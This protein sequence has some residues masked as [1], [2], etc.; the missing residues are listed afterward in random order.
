MGPSRL[1]RWGLAFALS[2]SVVSPAS[3]QQRFDA[4]RVD[5]ARL[6]WCLS[7][8]AEC[9]KPAADR[10][11]SEKSL[12]PATR[13]EKAP[14]VGSTLVLADRRR[15]DGERC[16]GFAFIECGPRLRIL[17]PDAPLEAAKPPSRE[18]PDA[19]RSGRDPPRAAP[20][21]PGR[22]PGQAGLARPDLVACQPG[23]L[24]ALYPPG[25]RL[26]YYEGDLLMTQPFAARGR[27]MQFEYGV[28][29][30]PGAEGVL[31]QVATRPFEAFCGSDGSIPEPAGL[32]RSGRV[33]RREGS[34]EVPF[35]ALP[36]A[37]VHPD[38]DPIPSWYV[39][40]VPV[41]GDPPTPVGWPSDAIAVF[42]DARPTLS[43]EEL[44]EIWGLQQYIEQGVPVHLTRFELVPYRYV[45]HWPPGCEVYRGR[46]STRNPVEWFGEF[47]LGAADWASETYAE[48][49]GFVVDAVVTILPFV[50]PEVAAIALDAALASA[51]IPPSIPNLDQMMEEGADYLATQMADELAAQVPAGHAMAELG[52]A[53]LR[54][55]IQ[56]ETKAALLDNARKARAAMEAKAGEYCVGREY[57]PHLK[58]TLRNDGRETVR[59]LRFSLGA[60]TNLLLPMGFTV[61]EIGPGES[62]VVPVDIWSNVIRNWAYARDDPYLATTTFRFTLTGGRTMAYLATEPDG[63]RTNE[64]PVRDGTGI[65]YTTP[66]RI[67]SFEP[68]VG[69]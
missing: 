46:G 19:A 6:D 64:T 2:F 54:R 13:F 51:G 10:F 16:D 52:K 17:L 58:I 49:K 7:W 62:L 21:A 26:W 50:P 37:S 38:A 33:S 35:G 65:D 11:C 39:R 14:R 68:F 53:E 41:A 34:F 4:P 44:Q 22:G 61:D 56:D 18:I 12:G 60:S 23:L 15:C 59:D 69:P 8:S 32:V 24:R 3:G 9:G 31:W 43:D 42:D 27:A 45:S 67:W 20:A 57:P 63:Y 66:E 48:I 55:R 29:K 1:V 47:V 40:V 25:A 36:A 5:G 28:E 30:V